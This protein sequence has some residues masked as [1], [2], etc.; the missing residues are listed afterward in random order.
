M[1]KESEEGREEGCLE[2]IQSWRR[3]TPAGASAE[4][5]GA[6]WNAFQDPSWHPLR[7]HVLSTGQCVGWCSLWR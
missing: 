3:E 4:R 2:S 7:A 1:K 6:G 5:C